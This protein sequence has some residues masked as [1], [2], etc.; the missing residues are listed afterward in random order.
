LNLAFYMRAG[1]ASEKGYTSQSHAAFLAAFTETLPRLQDYI[2]DQKPGDPEHDWAQRLFDQVT[3]P[4]QLNQ[5]VLK[6][7]AGHGMEDANRHSTVLLALQPSGELA[8]KY[9]ALI[10]NAS[11]SRAIEHLNFDDK[12][13]MQSWL[14]DSI[15]GFID[16]LEQ[17][18]LKVEGADPAA[19]AALI[20]QA[21]ALKDAATE[22]SSV[23][24]L[25][26]Q[27]VNLSVA[28]GGKDFWDK[29]S[30]T[31][32]AW[33]KAGYAFA[34]CVYSFAIVAGF[35]HSVMSFMKWDQLSK[36]DRAKVVVSTVQTA[37]K[38][39]AS[40]PEIITGTADFGKW[41][42]TQV[43]KLYRSCSDPDIADDLEDVERMLLDP[44]EEPMDYGATNLAELADVDNVAFELEGSSWIKVFNSTV[45]KVCQVIGVCAAVAFAVT[46]T[47]Q[48]IKDI[49][50]GAPLKTEVLDGIVLAANVGVAICAVAG[51]LTSATLVPVVGAVFAI[52]GI[53]AAL[54][55]MFWPPEP[56]PNP[57]E[58]F[59]KERL[60]PA[61]SGGARWILDAPDQWGIDKTVPVD[62]A[63]SRAAKV[64]LN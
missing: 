47:I 63:Y 59:M 6:V 40:M 2:R 5:A 10:T 62:N 20:A 44:G 22:V 12:E 42:F 34:R 50:A 46:S 32:S 15:Q 7:I 33:G 11:M 48:L 43:S 24:N 23:A 26:A 51:L 25:A 49:I 57:V 19:Q 36:N 8:Q 1:L 53:V 35:A 13:A 30:K 29:L 17:D 27:L 21:Q 31:E 28:A 39:I 37:A 52:I 56:P 55:E 38:L 16:A 45:G 3:T 60:V 64:A 41:S 4:M 58:V 14:T 61:A 9:H 18:K 54:I